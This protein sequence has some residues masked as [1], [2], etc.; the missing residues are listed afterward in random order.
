MN[1]DDHDDLDFRTASLATD[2]L[3]GDFREQL[4]SAMFLAIQYW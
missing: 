2:Q 3:N 1:L 4:V